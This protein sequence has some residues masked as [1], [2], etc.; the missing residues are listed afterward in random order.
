MIEAVERK[1]EQYVA[2]L[3]DR[4]AQM[5]LK[6][7]PAGKRLRARLILEI[8]GT[9]LRALKLAAVVEMIH[10][11]SLLHDDVLDAATVRRGR[12]SINA[13]FDNKTAIMFGDV[14]YSK[15]FYELVDIDRSVARIVSEAVVRLSL[16]ERQ[17]ILLAERFTVDRDAYIAMIDL[18]TAALIQ[19]AAEAAAQLAGKDRAIYRTYGRNLGIAFQMI[20][21][22]L[23]ITQDAATLGK[24]SMHDFVE[25]KTTLPYIDLYAALEGADRDRL[26]GMHGRKLRAEEQQ[27]IVAQME[28]HGILTRARDEAKTLITEAIALMH[29]A[30]EHSL[31]TI[32]RSMIERNF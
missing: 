29:R 13:A 31:E 20:D 19:A 9:G 10:A 24:P 23:D 18:K 22:L 16:G 26:R 7:L 15:A 4:D 27:W 2:Q 28:R 21:D 30:G 32:A 8:A 3:G 25:G 17:D 14:L 1:I 12:P 6:R 5:L 11:A